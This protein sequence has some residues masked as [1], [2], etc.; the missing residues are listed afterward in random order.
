MAPGKFGRFVIPA[1]G[2]TDPFHFVGGDGLAIART[3][4]NNATLRVP[5]DDSLS[6]RYDEKRVVGAVGGM[7]PV[8]RDLMP[9]GFQVLDEPLLVFKARVIA[10]DADFQWEWVGSS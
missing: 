5:T 2:A 7:G 1:K 9:G 3:T 8:I 10:A 4:K 6:G